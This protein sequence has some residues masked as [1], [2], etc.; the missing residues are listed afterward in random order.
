MFYKKFNNYV[1]LREKCLYT[2]L[3]WPVFSHIR[4]EYGKIQTRITPNADNFYAV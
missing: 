1:T 2:E 4:T 3:F